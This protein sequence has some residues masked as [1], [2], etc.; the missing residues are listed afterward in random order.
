MKMV[1]NK[2]GESMEVESHIILKNFWEY[3]FVKGTRELDVQK[4]LV[5][6]YETEFGS[7]YLPEI[8]PYIISKTKNL[9]EVLPAPG[10]HWEES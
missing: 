10:W 2:T 9:K 4:A 5:M 6:G 8:K 1:N 7:V 3:Y